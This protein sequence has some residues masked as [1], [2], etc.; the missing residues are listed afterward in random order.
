MA[1]AGFLADTR[2]A[3]APAASS[4]PAGGADQCGRGDPHH[5]V[6][7]PP[8]ESASRGMHNHCVI[9]RVRACRACWP[10][11]CG[12]I[13]RCWMPYSLQDL[14]EKPAALSRAL[15]QD[16]AATMSGDSREKRDAAGEARP[17]PGQR[18]AMQVSS[19]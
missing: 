1:M 16:G 12:H 17:R 15:G 7:F 11:R 19:K 3:G 18:P 2:C 9:T 5:G 6:G 4:W 14:V 13:S 8:G 10:P